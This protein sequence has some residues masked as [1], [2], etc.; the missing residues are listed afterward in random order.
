MQVEEELILS[1]VDSLKI[2]DSSITNDLTVTTTPTN[3]A[4]TPTGDKENNNPGLNSKTK[5]SKRRERM[6]AMKKAKKKQDELACTYCNLSFNEKLEFQ[7]LKRIQF[8]TVLQCAV[9]EMHYALYY[10]ERLHRYRKYRNTCAAL[11]L[12][13]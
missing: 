7:V 9:G 4:T 2:E 12:K 8:L 3:A 13:M 11:P 5:S 6:A 1:Q 10:K